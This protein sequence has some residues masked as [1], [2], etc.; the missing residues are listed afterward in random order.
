VLAHTEDLG[1]LIG[2]QAEDPQFG[3]ALKDL[4]DGKITPEDEIKS[5][6]DLIQRILPL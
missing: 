1:N 6:L 5:V 4:V 2:G 3:G